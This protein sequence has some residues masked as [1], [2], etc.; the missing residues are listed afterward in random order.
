MCAW[1]VELS[2]G[3][4]RRLNLIYTIEAPAHVVLPGDLR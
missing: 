4:T 3:E 2:A 1:R